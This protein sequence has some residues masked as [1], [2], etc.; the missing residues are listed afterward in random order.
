MNGKY[1]L[2]NKKGIVRVEEI[3]K[4]GVIMSAKSFNKNGKILEFMDYKRK[5]NNQEL[6]VYFE[7][8][9]KIG[10]FLYKGFRYLNNKN[11]IIE[12]IVNK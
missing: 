4:N 1:Q 9:D 8:Y 5:F 12:T 7:Q 3:Y 11:K 6:S 2:V 10:N